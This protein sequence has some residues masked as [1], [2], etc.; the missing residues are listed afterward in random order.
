MMENLKKIE[1]FYSSKNS[2]FD[3]YSNS[4]GKINKIT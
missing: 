3:L 1:N 4:K 2:I